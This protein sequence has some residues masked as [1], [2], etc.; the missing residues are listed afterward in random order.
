[1]FD[2][3]GKQNVFTFGPA[4]QHA[5]RKKLLANAYAKSGML[6]GPVAEEIERKVRDFLKL[7]EDS[8]NQEIFRSLHWY[9]LD[10]IT[11]SLYGPCFGGTA[12]MKG[13]EAHR[14]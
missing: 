9:S 14:A 3:Y 13:D 2:V 6:R 8:P 10:N 4:A 7:V 1:M 11:N 12:A 5:E